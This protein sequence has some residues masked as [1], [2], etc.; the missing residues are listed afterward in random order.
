M[1]V[2]EI[3]EKLN[4]RVFGGEDGLQNE[5][6][7]GYVSDLLSDVMGNADEGEVWV[8]LQ[9]HKNVMAISSLK[10]LAAVILVTDHEPDADMLEQANEEGI[11]VLGTEKS[12]FEVSGELY[13]LLK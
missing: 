4:L 13:Q 9:T 3:I 12:T 6:T 5:I 8:T 10:E 2:S 7:G 1:K 11:P